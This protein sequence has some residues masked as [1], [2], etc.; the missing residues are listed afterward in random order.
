MIPLPLLNGDTLILDNSSLELFQCCPRAGQYGICLRRRAVR[1]NAALRFGGIAHK[2]LEVRYRSGNP[3]LE[4]TPEVEVAMVEAARREFDRWY[5]PE[6]EY[7]NFDRMVD[8][9]HNYGEEHRYESFEIARTP[10]GA[11]FI[12]V[13][14]AIDLGVVGISGPILVQKLVR[15][16]EHRYVREGTPYT[17]T[18]PFIHIIWQ[19]RIDLAY[20]IGSMT[21]IM[22]HKT[23][24]MATN[25]AEF[26]IS[27]QFKGYE[28]ATEKILGVP[29]MGTVINRI[30]VRKPSKTGVA[31]TFERKLIPTIRSHIDEWQTD[32]LHLITDFVEM[33]RRGYMA[34]ATVWCVNKYGTCQFHKVC[35]L[36]G[37]AQRDVMLWSGE[38]EE[39]LWN[40]LST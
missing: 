28:W 3:M 23:A 27:H 22:D 18:L 35:T 9:I 6:D 40:P 1:D 31:F 4:Q 30:V 32:V 12:E 34:K 5:P 10:N 29:V 16:A 36:D 15:D 17:A 39:N 14:F 21:Y 19:G 8:L 33:V 38:Y 13:P 24:S 2:A 20:T 7:R 11:S 25:M 26:D 37:D